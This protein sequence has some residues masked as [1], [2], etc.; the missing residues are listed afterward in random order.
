MQK[1]ELI[2]A[3]SELEVAEIDLNRTLQEKQN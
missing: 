1:Q 3:N 2:K